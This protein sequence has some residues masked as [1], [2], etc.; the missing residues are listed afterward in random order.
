VSAALLLGLRYER[1]ERPAVRRHAVGADVV[2]GFRVIRRNGDVGLI[3][4]LTVLQTAVRGAL[5]VLVVVMAI[6][7]LDTGEA[8]VGWLQGAMGIGAIAGSV[9]AARLV[10][11]RALARWLGLAVGL[12][13]APLI[14][15]GLVPDEVAALV[16][17]AV[18][19]A[20]NALVDVSAFSL[21]GRMVAD[22]VLARV[23]GTLESLIAVTVA[24]GALL[25]PVV[26][27]VLGTEGALVAIGVVAPAG[28]ALAWRRLTRI[29]RRLGVREDDIGVLRGVP[30]LRTLPVPVIEQLGRRLI[31][32]EL[33]S[34]ARLFA[35]GDP[36]DRFY[37]IERG[38]V[39]VLDGDRLVR[40]MGPGE[41]FGEIALLRDVARTMTV[42]AE[43]DAV[44]HA[45]ER[46]DFLLAISGFGSAREAAGAAMERHLENAPGPIMS[47]HA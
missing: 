11:S 31:R 32:V 38:R 24:A 30:M 29:D 44:L 7:L 46:R 6:D 10:G 36:G 4:G 12:W 15:I 47:P 33:P 8:G 28:C 17:L 22:D 19:G 37:V 13:G 25:T 35:A 42:E 9:A 40:T 26:I 43:E 27:D 45:I 14:L 18:I 23:F 21:P 1:I 16:A 20:A 2:E 34:D 39:R 41:G 5:S 3:I